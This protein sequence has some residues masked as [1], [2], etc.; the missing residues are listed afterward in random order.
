MPSKKVFQKMQSYG[1]IALKLEKLTRRIDEPFEWDK[2]SR[3]LS[4][5]AKLNA[6]ASLQPVVEALSRDS[7][8]YNR[9]LATNTIRQLWMRWKY[10][11]YDDEKAYRERV[12]KYIS[13]L[14]WTV[15]TLELLLKDRAVGPT[16]LA[17]MALSQME[18]ASSRMHRT[19]RPLAVHI[20]QH[21]SASVRVQAVQNVYYLYPY[22]DD[23]VILDEAALAAMIAAT[24]DSSEKVRDWAIFTLHNNVQSNDPRVEKAFRDAFH[25]ED[26][27]S[28]AYMEA[29]NGLVVQGGEGEV[30]EVI[31]QNLKREDCGTGWLDA[32]NACKSKKCH[33]AMKDMKARLTKSNPKD[34]RLDYLKTLLESS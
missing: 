34:R 14:A 32:A 22:G 23:G 16:E 26:P 27:D 15:P 2:I 12:K 28:D 19:L 20:M 1:P 13:A 5:L 24:Y 29:V 3:L 25:R 30:V 18:P 4:T 33:E 6:N 9:E 21:S 31:C 17:V 10:L 8:A 7:Y 11:P